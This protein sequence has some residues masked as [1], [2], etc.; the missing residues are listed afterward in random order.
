[1]STERFADIP[2]DKMTPEQRKVAEVLR[3]S[4]RKGL[5]G[6]FHTLLRNPELCDRVRHLGDQVRYDNVLSAAMK[7]FVIL[8][9]ARFW[10]AQ[11]E[12]QAHKRLGL[13]AGL[14]PSIADAIAVGKRPPKMTDEESL[15]Y[16]FVHQLVYDKDVSDKTYDDALA[17]Y[18]EKGLL[19]VICL[20][21]YYG[22]VS[23]ILNAK[24][25]PIPE[26]TTPLAPLD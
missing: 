12:W 16:D 18:G 14:D 26:G 6:P 22:F 24:R 15:L 20:A 9:V 23:H 13:A 1:M 21:G 2:D 8:I 25:Y 17:R 19:D 7:E 3:A 4:P 10:S 11:F 5:P